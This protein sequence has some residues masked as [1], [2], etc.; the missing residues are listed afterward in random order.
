M[1]TSQTFMII[2]ESDVSRAHA[3]RRDLLSVPEGHR[4]IDRS[5]ICRTGLLFAR[6]RARVCVI[7]RLHVRSVSRPSNGLCVRRLPTE[8]TVI[9]NNVSVWEQLTTVKSA[10]RRIQNFVS[11]VGDDFM[12]SGPQIDQFQQQFN[13]WY[14][15]L[16]IFA[17]MSP[18]CYDWNLHL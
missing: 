5:L 18:A 1:F 6:A 14:R 4:C 10:K 9:R 12:L 11:R 13:N 16:K 3:H 7:V 17:V 8:E 2:S 15:N